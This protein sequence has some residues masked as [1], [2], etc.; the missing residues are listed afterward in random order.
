M[1]ISNITVNNGTSDVTF[2]CSGQEGLKSSYLAPGAS[3]K[4]QPYMQIVGKSYNSSSSQR[5]GNSFIQVFVPVTNAVTGAVSYAPIAVRFEWNCDVRVTSAQIKQVRCMTANL[6]LNS[7]ME[8][9]ID[10]GI[11][12]A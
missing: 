8:N 10:N 3:F 9:A 7:V 2:S 11:I 1:S 6:L 12:P 4:E 5:R